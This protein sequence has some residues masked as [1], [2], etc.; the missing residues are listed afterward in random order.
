[1]IGKKIKKIRK[2]R[3]L[4]QKELGIMCGFSEETA[5]ARIRHYEIEKRIPQKETIS[6]IAAALEIDE[7]SLYKTDIKS[8]EEV[9]HFLMDIDAKPVKIN[10]NYYL[11]FSNSTYLYDAML[12]S[13]VELEEK[14]SGEELYLK[15]QYFFKGDE[16]FSKFKNESFSKFK[17][18]EEIKQLQIKQQE[19]MEEIKQLQIKQ[20]ELQ[21]QI[22]EIAADLETAEKE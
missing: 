16:S 15:K 17:K 10:G 6:I 8:F 20:Q 22:D 11:Q 19:K 2:L 1:M 12:R 13:W 9:T 21:R 3:G 14:Y 18:M 4:T 5:D 7:A